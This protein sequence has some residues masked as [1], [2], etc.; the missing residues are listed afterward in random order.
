MHVTDDYGCEVA[1]RDFHNYINT[2]EGEARETE[3]GRGKENN[4]IIER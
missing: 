2:P 1:I 4:N 3:R